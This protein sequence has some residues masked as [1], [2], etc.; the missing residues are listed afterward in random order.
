MGTHRDRQLDPDRVTKEFKRIARKARIWDLRLRDLRH[1]HAS[2]MLA[3][4][5][6]LKVTSERPGHSSITMT[7][8][9]YS[10]VQSTVQKGRLSALEMRGARE[11]QTGG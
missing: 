2:L 7:G 5:V 10:H 3:E 4:G 9:L 6:H 8:N 1:T 11:W